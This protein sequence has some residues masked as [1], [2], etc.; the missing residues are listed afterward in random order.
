MQSLLRRFG[1]GLRLA[2]AFALILVLL[3]S[4]AGVSMWR[5]Y[6]ADRHL[7][8]IVSQDT[9]KIA[10]ANEVRDSVRH[11]AIALRDLT[12][13]DDVSAIKIEI[14]LYREARA[15][16]IES[17]KAFDALTHSD[18]STEKANLRDADKQVIPVVDAIREAALSDDAGGREKARG[19]V[20]DRLRPLQGAQAQ[21][22]QSVL[23]RLESDARHSVD[24]AHAAQK[25]TLVLVGSVSVVSIMF[26][27]MFAWL[28]TRSI[29]QPLGSAVEFA[30]AIADKNLQAGIV[31]SGHDEVSVLQAALQA[32]RLNL[33]EALLGV[34]TASDEVSLAL[35]DV[36]EGVRL[37]AE[38]ADRQDE[39]TRLID[40]ATKSLS[41]TIADISGTAHLVAEKSCGSAKLAQSGMALVEAELS[42]SASMVS[43]SRHTG[44]IIIKLNDSVQ[45]ISS[46]SGEIGEIASQTN[47]LALNAAIEAARAGEAGRGFAIVADEVRELAEHTA[48]STRRIADV[49]AD[50][51][52]QVT[53]AM[54]ATSGVQAEVD[55]TVQQI[56]NSEDVLQQ[57]LIGTREVQVLMQSIDTDISSQGHNSHTTARHVQ[58]IAALTRDVANSLHGIDSRLASIESN[59]DELE[60]LVAAFCLP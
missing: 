35:H 4:V 31:V 13:Q 46:V 53:I 11:Q 7:E 22:L 57:I 26:G 24:D 60:R 23:L 28:I 34:Q 15:R 39:R 1:I 52:K 54:G 2:C 33:I 41:E 59:A 32:M 29:S 49:I 9:R 56:R 38:Q 6:I 37:L 19:L 48:Q 36:A 16:F 58:D 3:L 10:L 51:Q 5:L 12:M 45:L 20:R 40:Q 18:F 21:A 8:Q 50:I 14:K 47:L 30:K 55:A 25:A 17:M 27:L 44:D 42:A 43:A